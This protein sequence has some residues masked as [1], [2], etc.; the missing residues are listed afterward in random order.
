MGEAWV[1]GCRPSLGHFEGHGLT[2][3]SARF[4]VVRINPHSRQRKGRGLLVD[5][6]GQDFR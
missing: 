5:S 3:A 6:R 2:E 1:F 4:E